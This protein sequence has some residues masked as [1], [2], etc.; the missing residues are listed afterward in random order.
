MQLSATDGKVKFLTESKELETKY[1]VFLPKTQNIGS[2]YLFYMLDF[3]MPS[4][5]RKYQNGMNINPDIFK[6]LQVTY[7]PEYKYQKELVMILDDIQFM[8]DQELNEKEKWEYFKKFHL[9]GM[10][11]TSKGA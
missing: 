6:Y 3:E 11:P 7:Y 10:F 2:R 8:Y 9:N 4:F 1:G 5:L